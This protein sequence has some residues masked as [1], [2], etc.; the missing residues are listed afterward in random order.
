MQLWVW[1]LVGLTAFIVLSLWKAT[2][3]RS[4]LLRLCLAYALTLALM[5]LGRGLGLTPSH[6]TPPSP[7][8]PVTRPAAPRTAQVPTPSATPEPGPRGRPPHLMGHLP[9]GCELL[10]LSETASIVGRPLEFDA[11]HL[12]EGRSRGYVDCSYTERAAFSPRQPRYQVSFHLSRRDSGRDADLGFLGRAPIPGGAGDVR[13]RADDADEGVSVRTF[14]SHGMDIVVRVALREPPRGVGRIEAELDLAYRLALQLRTRAQALSLEE[15]FLRR[16]AARA[17]RPHPEPVPWGPCPEEEKAVF[18]LDTLPPEREWRATLEPVYFLR[19]RFGTRVQV[20][21][22]DEEGH[23]LDGKEPEEVLEAKERALKTGREDDSPRQDGALVFVDLASR[24][25]WFRFGPGAPAL[26][27]PNGR[28]F[29]SEWHGPDLQAKNKGKGIVLRLKALMDAYVRAY[30][31]LGITGP[32]ELDHARP[33]LPTGRLRVAVAPPPDLSLKNAWTPWTNPT[34]AAP[35]PKPQGRPCALVPLPEA[36]SLLG[37]PLELD[38]RPLHGSRDGASLTCGYTGRGTRSPKRPRY[39]V[40]LHVAERLPEPERWQPIPGEPEGRRW[41][42]EKNDRGV[43]VAATTA[44]GLSVVARVARRDVSV[45]YGRTE[46]ELLTAYHFAR[47][48]SMRA[49]DL[50][51]GEL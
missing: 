32:P 16:E 38:A 25:A 34:F 4:P 45:V 19:G 51:P 28:P 9:D 22:S 1:G 2:R 30:A 43:S 17:P 48:L 20:I 47:L 8:E 5:G 10:P 40:E 46:V 14:T 3:R 37:L 21:V 27:L 18:W 23:G 35:E 41:R 15:M 39:E 31:A 29:P 33:P 12:L 6:Q 26:T 50:T 7:R 11:F 13:W 24:R 49:Q 44:H 42:V 36:A